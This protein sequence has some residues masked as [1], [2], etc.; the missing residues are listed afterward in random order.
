M[1]SLTVTLAGCSVPVPRDPGPALPA[2]FSGDG[3]AVAS[4]RWWRHFDDPRLSRQVECALQRNFSLESSWRRLQQAE[5]VVERTSSGLLPTLDGSGSA[6]F[7]EGTGFNGG[8]PSSE[9]FGI[10]L[11]AR[12][13]IDLWGRIGARIEAER[14]RQRA[15]L[16]DYRA[17][18][19]TLSAEVAQTWYAR[20][21][22]RA[23]VDLIQAQ[24]ETNEQVRDQL[25]VRLREGQGRAVD[26][27]R[28]A[29]LVR[30]TREQLSVARAEAEVLENRLQV[31][32]GQ[33][34]VGAVPAGDFPDFPAAP[35]RASTRPARS[36]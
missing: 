11:S 36:S 29:Q 1:L 28:Q 22:A 24:I 6:E 32:Q 20:V 35:P 26:L 18:A 19:V 30:A 8:N 21:A 33:A 12:Y 5:A 2:S 16:A 3:S 4:D 17:A 15:R 25:Q 9:Q 13:E 10:G 7:F 34:P 27:L 23:R 31:L 14:S